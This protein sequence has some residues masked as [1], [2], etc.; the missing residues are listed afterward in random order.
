[1]TKEEVVMYGVGKIGKNLLPY[2]QKHYNVAFLS[3][4][5]QK[6]WGCEYDNIEVR[7]P[8]S[9]VGF[10]G[11]VIVTTSLENY[12]EIADHLK[13]VG[14]DESQ[15]GRGKFNNDTL[16]VEIEPYVLDHL[17]SEKQLIEYDLLQND[18]QS[19]A[20]ILVLCGFYT[21]LLVQLIRNCKK[22]MPDLRISIL[23]GSEDYHAELADC[24]EH[25]YYY[26]SISD[27]KMIIDHMPRHRV[28]QTLWVENIWVYLSEQLRAKCDSLNI[29]IGGSDFYRTSETGLNYKEKLVNL[30]DW[31]GTG[32]T[33]TIREFIKRY[34]HAQ[35]KTVMANFGIP[36]L[37]YL[38]AND[39]KVKIERRRELGIPEDKIIIA[40]GYNAGEAHQHLKIIRALEMVE[41]HEK[42][43][44]FLLFL[45]TY[46][47]NRDEYIDEV[48]KEAIDAG[49]RCKV[50][51]SFLSYE[52][53]AQYE[54]CLDVL[55]SMQTTDQLSSTILENLYCGNIIVAGNWLPYG[56]LSE[57]GLFFVSFGDEEELKDVI[58][59][60]LFRK[61]EYLG[62]CKQNR[63]KV[64]DLSSWDN[65]VKLWARLWG[66]E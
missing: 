45:M 56:I 10:G 27:A 9:I 58:E 24:V 46:P 39:G 1:M 23:V 44:I 17:S 66:Y 14:I 48:V 63:D 26:K 25:I 4:E 33:E 21:H 43:R 7:S 49:F 6:L 19:P 5:N 2:I 59:D 18:T 20:E 40:C 30:A 65:A 32:N 64:Y 55:I 22:R 38:V 29:Y 3:D 34:P 11:K 35:N 16:D 61:D 36:T 47:K 42:D 41:E 12:L 31:I 51:T 52:Q 54:E 8:D 13:S 28:I 50:V 15:I 62:Y 37:D 53:M 57:M 60:I